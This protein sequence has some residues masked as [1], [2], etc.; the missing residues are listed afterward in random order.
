LTGEAVSKRSDKVRASHLGTADP[1]QNA[2]SNRID[3]PKKDSACRESFL[4]V[5]IC[6]ILYLL[7]E[8]LSDKISEKNG[9]QAP[10]K[11]LEEQ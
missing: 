7:P 1:V 11:P 8:I 10:N 6:D 4:C 9:A 3:F 5:K 2:E